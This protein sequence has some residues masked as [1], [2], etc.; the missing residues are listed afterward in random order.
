MQSHHRPPSSFT[1]DAVSLAPVVPVEYLQHTPDRP[2]CGWDPTCPC[3]EDQEYINVVHT[4]LQ[5]GLLTEEE[6]MRCVQGKNI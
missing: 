3:H 6:A 5:A 4:H 1:D 2:C